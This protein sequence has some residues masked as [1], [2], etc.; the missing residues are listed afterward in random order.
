M[1]RWTLLITVLV[2]LASCAQDEE[3]T[4]AS[5]DPS[6]TTRTILVTTTTPT[7]PQASTTTAVS[8]N[9]SKPAEGD[10]ASY[11]IDHDESFVGEMLGTGSRVV[12]DYTEL[13]F[14]LARGAPA[15]GDVILF[16]R[17]NDEGT[18]EDLVLVRQSGGLVTDGLSLT[19]DTHD[20]WLGVACEGENPIVLTTSDGAPLRSWRVDESWRLTET[21]ILDLTPTETKSA[22]ATNT[23]TQPD[24]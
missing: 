22:C 16:R 18:H 19:G 5:L 24:T 12:G 20:V 8:T 9:P 2:M 13:R 6:T 14:A 10:D 4:E 3:A 1:S 15:P 11:R 17:W 7:D 21:S 23:M